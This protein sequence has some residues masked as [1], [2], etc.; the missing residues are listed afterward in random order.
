MK[1]HHHPTMG[2]LVFLST[3]QDTHLA[4]PKTNDARKHTWRRESMLLSQRLQSG[5]IIAHAI[6]PQSSQLVLISSLLPY[7]SLT[8]FLAF[9]PSLQTAQ[10]SLPGF[11]T[12][13][14]FW[15][16]NRSF[17]FLF[18]SR[19]KR[20]SSAHYKRSQHSGAML[21]TPARRK[22]KQKTL[23]LIWQGKITGDLSQQTQN[24]QPHRRCIAKLPIPTVSSGILEYNI[25]AGLEKHIVIRKGRL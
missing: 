8:R 23:K 20:L 10:S 19:R 15:S 9:P 12:T 18:L 25:G 2:W 4:W 1:C 11:K 5:V 22:K 6:F 17:C 14:P 21:E 3:P 7:L 24:Q 16:L 13:R